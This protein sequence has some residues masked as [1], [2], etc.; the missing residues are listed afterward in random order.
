MGVRALPLHLDRLL[1]HEVGER[2]R[3]SVHDRR[4]RV[5]GRAQRRVRAPPDFRAGDGRAR[6]LPLHTA[7]LVVRIGRDA[8]GAGVRGL[9]GRPTGA[10]GDWSVDRGR[11]HVHVPDNVQ[12][13]GRDRF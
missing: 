6:D 3:L 7:A 1:V 2:L 12:D 13:A 4:G 8:Q 9:R 11:V 5:R 10:D